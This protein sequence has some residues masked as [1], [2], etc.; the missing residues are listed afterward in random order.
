MDRKG[1]VQ[2]TSTSKDVALV[3]TLPKMDLKTIL[4]RV[5]R[6][7]N[8]VTCF[9]MNGGHELY[10]IRGEGGNVFQR[11]LLCQHE[12]KGWKIDRKTDKR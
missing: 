1:R 8:S 2:K 10:I 11:C 4:N 7:F 3:V 5:I 12:T 6:G 9:L